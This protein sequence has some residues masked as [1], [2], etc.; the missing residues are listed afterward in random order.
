MLLVSAVAF[1]AMSAGPPKKAIA[2]MPAIVPAPA[3]YRAGDGGF[4]LPSRTVLLVDPGS[5]ESRRIADYLASKLEAP[6]GIRFEIHSGGA[7]PGAIS[8]SLRGARADLGTEGYELISGDEG[9]TI[10]ALSPNGLFYGVQTFLQ[11]IPKEAASPKFMPNVKWSLPAATIADKP[12]FS[13]RGFLLD[14]SRHFRDAE[15]VKHYIDLLAYQK[16]NV[17]HWHLVDDQGWRLEIK[18][19]PKLTEVGGWRMEDG[20]KYGGF[21]TQNQV[22]EIVQYAADRFI[23]VVPEIEMPGHCNAALS[24]Y[25]ENSCTGG[26]FSVPALWGVYDDVYCAGKET[27]FNF[28]ENVLDEVMELFPSKFIHIGGDE[29]PKTKWHACPFCQERIKNEH[30]KD[31]GELQSYF[32]RRIDKYLTSKGR[33]LL[34]WDEILEGGLAQGATVQSWRGMEGAIQAAKEG[35]DVIS[36]PTSRCYLD[37]SYDSIPVDK[38]YDFEPVPDILTPEQAKHVLGGEGNIWAEHT[39][40]PQDTDR[41]VF[42]RLSALAEVFW[43]PKERRNWDDFSPRL[44]THLDRLAMMGVKYWVK[45]PVLKSE[46]DVLIDQVTATF[47]TPPKGD[48]IVYTTDGSPPT[49]AS[50]RYRGPITLTS[51]TT[52]TCAMLHRTR[53]SEAVKKTLRKVDPQSAVVPGGSTG[54]GVKYFEGTFNRIPDF[55]SMTPAWSG[56]TSAIGLDVA[57]RKENYGLQFT[58]FITVPKDGVYTFFLVADDGSRLIIGDEPLLSFDRP[59]PAGERRAQVALKAG[60]HPIRIDYF[61]GGG[62]A[63]LRLEVVAPGDKRVAVPAG[64]LSAP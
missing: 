42:P 3:Y 16:M 47:D 56:T 41:Q 9:V 30:L 12:R 52:I 8:L 64:W 63:A 58:G 24:A 48:T 60:A 59:R 7:Y 57:K 49:P 51:T 17:F 34:G 20:K 18:K 43:S 54:L 38:A 62:A 46:A 6:T 13:W 5:S 14:T 36:S 10:R 33:R 37:Y 32:I 27:T 2:G 50:L 28:V 21:Y 15:F 35:H 29:V 61:Q 23:T 45:P 1:L 4:T 40:L 22:R 31:E 25:P 19:Y 44:D 39:P 11:M 55:D 26:P 53:I